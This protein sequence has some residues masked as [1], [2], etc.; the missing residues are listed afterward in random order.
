[1]KKSRWRMF[2][3]SVLVALCLSC[4][5]LA[6]C[7]DDDDSDGGRE[8][9]TF[10]YIKNSTIYTI[11][12]DFGTDNNFSTRLAPNEIRGFNMDEGRSHLL[13]TVVLGGSNQVISE[14]FTNFN[15]DRTA[16]DNEWEGFVCSWY[17]DIVR[18]SGFGVETGD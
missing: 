4:G 8:D 18:E 15:V 17:V 3:L 2:G 14:F 5:V 10:G 12:I 13:H 11:A 7:N 1:M 16:L 9:P 6:G